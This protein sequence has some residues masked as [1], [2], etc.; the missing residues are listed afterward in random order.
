VFG[1]QKTILRG[2]AG[3][4]TNATP[5]RRV[6]HGCHVPFSNSA[7][8]HFAYTADPAVSYINGTSAGKSPTTP[9]G[10][11]GVQKNLADYDGVSIQPG[12]RATVEEQYAGVRGLVG[13]SSTHM[14]QT[15]ISNTLPTSD[16][17][18]RKNVCG[19]ACGGSSAMP[20]T[21][22]LTWAIAASTWSTTKATP[23]PWSAGD[24]PG[25][26]LARRNRWRCLH[27]FAH[28]GCDRCP[29]LQQPAEPH[30]P[31][32]LVRYIRLRPSA[33]R[34]RQ[35]DYQLPIFKHSKGLAHNL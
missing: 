29:A 14:S 20:T 2:G 32:L 4:S 18:D 19:G 34:G 1:N 27:L 17:T 31:A 22:D 21:I 8:T 12:S 23:L 7:T 13:N 30:E 25:H 3:F 11:T 24:L 9:Q 26:R 6:Q 5:A 16:L 33:D 15:S 35:L 28:L 10:F